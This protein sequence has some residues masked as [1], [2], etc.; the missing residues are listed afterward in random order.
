M[1]IWELASYFQIPLNSA[2]IN[3]YLWRLSR[4]II[5]IAPTISTQE[6]GMMNSRYGEMTGKIP[7][8]IKSQLDIFVPRK[9]G[10]STVDKIGDKLYNYIGRRYRPRVRLIAPLPVRRVPEAEPMP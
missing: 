2:F 5:R 8:K 1:K 9:D 4:D 10:M 6:K 3:T 7:V